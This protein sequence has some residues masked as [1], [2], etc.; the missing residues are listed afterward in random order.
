MIVSIKTPCH[1]NPIIPYRYK[2]TGHTLFLNQS[3]LRYGEASLEDLFKG[4]WVK[5][6]GKSKGN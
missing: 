5:M 4:K 3:K 6:L 1:I 2:L